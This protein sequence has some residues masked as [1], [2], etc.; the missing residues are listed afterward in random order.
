MNIINDHPI[1]Q[2]LDDPYFLSLNGDEVVTK[3]ENADVLAV[4][5]ECRYQMLSYGDNMITC[6]AHPEILK[7]EAMETIREHESGLL[8][9]C[10]DLHDIVDATVGFANDE[11]SKRFLGNITEWLLG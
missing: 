5:A 11:A 8:I 1:F 3:P 4:N 10:G 7:D 2:G 6:Q 9:R